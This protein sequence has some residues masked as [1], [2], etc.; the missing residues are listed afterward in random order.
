[1]TLGFLILFT[2]TKNVIVFK[3]Q[4]RKSHNRSIIFQDVD[5]TKTGIPNTEDLLQILL[6]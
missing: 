1:M 6:Y 4:D 2:L 5:H 3:E